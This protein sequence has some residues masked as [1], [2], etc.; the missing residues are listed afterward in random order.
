[1]DKPKSFRTKE[2]LVKALRHSKWQSFFESEAKLKR[3]NLDELV[4]AAVGANTF[5]AFR[6]LQV[7]PSHL[8]RDWAREQFNPGFL[9]KLPGIRKQE[10]FDRELK[11]LANSLRRSWKSLGGADLPFGPSMKL[12]SLIFKYLCARDFTPRANEGFVTFLHVPL[13]SFTLAT[14]RHVHNAACAGCQVPAGATMGWVR[15]AEAY[16][17]VQK[18]IRCC[19][20]AAGVPAIA[21]DILAWNKPHKGLAGTKR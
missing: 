5:R 1:M 2:E 10:E 8:F 3:A 18:T 15:T 9:V 7:R 19:T 17:A 12:P 4:K 6:N 20:E 21:L 16:D 13:D 14:I 11:G